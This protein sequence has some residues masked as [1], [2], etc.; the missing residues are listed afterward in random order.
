MVISHMAESRVVSFISAPGGV[1]KTTIAFILGLFARRMSGKRILFIDLDPSIG[2]SFM[3]LRSRARIYDIEKNKQT[4]SKLLD[5]IISE[6]KDIDLG[7]Y[8]HSGKYKETFLDIVVPDYHLCEVID[9]LWYGPSAKKEIK[10]RR[11]I[12]YIKQQR[13]YDLIIIDTIPFYDR[14]Y[15]V[16]AMYASDY[17]IVPVRPTVIDVYRTG[18]MLKDLPRLLEESEESLYKGRLGMIFN[19]VKSS[20]QRTRINKVYCKELETKITP[21]IKFFNTF[22]PH[23][24]SFSRI[25]TSDEQK[26]DYSEVEKKFNSLYQEIKGFIGI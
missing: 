10:L 7:R 24:I 11:L 17:I 21:Y 16:L 2:L 1:G 14:K 22:L 8:I 15:T 13:P 4:L 23:S 6:C 18:L 5:E 25:A 26:N 12:E 20:K 3:V 19:M 9:K